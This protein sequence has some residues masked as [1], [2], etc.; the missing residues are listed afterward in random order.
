MRAA[1]ANLGGTGRGVGSG[2]SGDQKGWATV[3]GASKQNANVSRMRSAMRKCTRFDPF[4]SH[5]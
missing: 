1:G 4:I 5:L 2:D 3:R